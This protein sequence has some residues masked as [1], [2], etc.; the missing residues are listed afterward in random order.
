MFDGGSLLLEVAEQRV[1]ARHALVADLG[2][3]QLRVSE[4]SPDVGDLLGDG[5]DV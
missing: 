3:H 5:G 1:Q 4:A 2:P